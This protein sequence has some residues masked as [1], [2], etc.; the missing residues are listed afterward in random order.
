MRAVTQ[1][2]LKVGPAFVPLPF[3]PPSEVHW[4]RAI[5][6]TKNE[7][8]VYHA[9]AAATAATKASW[10]GFSRYYW[11]LLLVVA[12]SISLA[13]LGETCARLSLESKTLK[14]QNAGLV[15]AAKRQA[16]GEFDSGNFR[17]AAFSLKQ[18]G[19]YPPN[20][21][22]LELLRA[23]IYECSGDF[24]NA[25]NAY[26][27]VVSKSEAS[28]ETREA[29]LFCRRMASERHPVITPSRDVLYRLYE[30]LMQRG[31]FA[32][33]RFIALDLRPDMEPLRESVGALLHEYDADAEI[34]PA[35][36]GE[37]VDV[38]NRRNQ[39]RSDRSASRP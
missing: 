9:P 8:T 20:D 15:E 5:P 36:S 10:R 38:K 12:V 22:G 28:A 1:L 39:P 2:D 19:Y 37:R 6:S 16:Q 3:D 35:E 23:R 24:I 11:P 18:V 17:K 4:S 34:T 31:Q 26:Q 13:W 33:A 32:Q 29:L 21:V 14:E 7:L 30:E 27:R 25:A